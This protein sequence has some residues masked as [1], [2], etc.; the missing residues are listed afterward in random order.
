MRRYVAPL[1]VEHVTALV[2]VTQVS[3]LSAPDPGEHAAPIA[4]LA[5]KSTSFGTCQSNGLFFLFPSFI[6]LS[7]DFYCGSN[8]DSHFPERHPYYTFITY[9]YPVLSIIVRGR[10]PICRY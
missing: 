7:S 4:D 6:I 8:R 2:A 1:P 10:R 9:I 5:P 3:P